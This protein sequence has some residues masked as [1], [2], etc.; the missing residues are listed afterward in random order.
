M[1]DGPTDYYFSLD[2]A[3][4]ELH[5]FASQAELISAKGKFKPL[6]RPEELYYAEV[7]RERSA[8][9]WPLVCMAPVGLAVSLF[10]V[11]LRGRNR[12]TPGATETSSM[13]R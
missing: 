5:K 4:G 6:Q 8:L 9:F 2:L 11:S 3:T 10:F 7:N 12:A 13:L 1:E